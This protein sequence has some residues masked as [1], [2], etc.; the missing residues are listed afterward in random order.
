MMSITYE[1]F[2]EDYNNPL[3]SAKD[4]ETRIGVNHHQYLKLR[5][6]A[7]E[8]NDITD[9]RNRFY[10]NSNFYRY[11]NKTGYYE[12]VKKTGDEVIYVGSFETKEI[13]EYIVFECLCV[14][15]DIEKIQ[16]IINKNKVKPKHYTHRNGSYI[17]QKAINGKMHYFCTVDNE[18]QAIRIVEFLERINWDKS[19]LT[20]E[21]LK[22]V[23]TNV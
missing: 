2:I 13:A 5:R 15:W 7:I 1:K 23:T 21:F 17:I 16:D 18:L 14:N 19:K 10:E 11:N 3:L 22:Q 9:S 6:K 12:I 4:V 8:N 20:T